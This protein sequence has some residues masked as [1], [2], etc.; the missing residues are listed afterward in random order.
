MNITLNEEKISNEITK[1]WLQDHPY[2]PAKDLPKGWELRF[3]M[4]GRF[5]KYDS[6]EHAERKNKIVIRESGAEVPFGYCNQMWEELKANLQLNDEIW[7]Y[8]GGG[9]EAIY[10]IRDGLTVEDMCGKYKHP[11]RGHYI[12]LSCY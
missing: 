12:C 8:G 1:R 4:R 3:G 6:I 11:R 5:L 7:R 10:I 2:D 9:G